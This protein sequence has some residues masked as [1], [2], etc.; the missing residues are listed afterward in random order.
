MSVRVIARIRPLQK[1]E[2][3]GDVIVR[4]DTSAPPPAK[5]NDITAGAAKGSEKGGKLK[6][7]KEGKPG[8]EKKNVVRIP[9]PKNGSEEYTFKFNSV[10]DGDA[11]QQDIFDAEG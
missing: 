3:D 6:G 8:L 10:Y 11:T 5:K 7:Q 4:C 1:T 2:R 9:N